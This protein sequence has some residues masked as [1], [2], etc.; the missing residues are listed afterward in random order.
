MNEIIS[1]FVK[2]GN[3]EKHVK[4]HPCLTVDNPPA[5]LQ[6]GKTSASAAEA[7]FDEIDNHQRFNLMTSATTSN[8]HTNS[9]KASTKCCKA[10]MPLNKELLSKSPSSAT[11]ETATTSSPV[12]SSTSSS[13]HNDELQLNRFA[14]YF[15]I[16]GLDLDTG[17][18]PDR[19]TGK[20]SSQSFIQFVSAQSL[21]SPILCLYCYC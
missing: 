7:T 3:G 13:A 8:V 4:C 19:F 14:D 2:N 21:T 18:E 6:E 11:G 1:S 16:C 10:E 9:A 20:V 12:S 15:V 17:L 5:N